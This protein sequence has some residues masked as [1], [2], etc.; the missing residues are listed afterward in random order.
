[1]PG[2]PAPHCQWDLHVCEDVKDS[3]TP[4]RSFVEMG[5]VSSI[6]ITEKAL[7]RT[8]SGAHRHPFCE[9]KYLL[10]TYVQFSSQHTV[11][12]GTRMGSRGGT[13]EPE[14]PAGGQRQI[15]RRVPSAPRGRKSACNP[16]LQGMP[17][18]RLCLLVNKKQPSTWVSAGCS[19]S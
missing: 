10:F 15:F 3:D 18:D 9:C 1:M 13:R 7:Q 5:D 12:V 4:K 16:D 19:K 2:C 14:T 8:S 11:T 6:S 17:M